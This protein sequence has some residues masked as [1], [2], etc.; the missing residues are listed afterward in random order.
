MGM[1]RTFLISPFGLCLSS[2]INEA[3]ETYTSRSALLP[4]Q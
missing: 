3:I 1:A 4:V 2:G